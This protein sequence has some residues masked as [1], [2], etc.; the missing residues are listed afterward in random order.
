VLAA[1]EVQADLGVE[2]RETN[3]V[4]HQVQLRECRGRGHPQ[5]TT[6]GTRSLA[7]VLLGCLH[8]GEDVEAVLVKARAGVGEAQPP[9]RSVEEP[10]AEL[11]LEQGDVLAHHRARQAAPAAGGGEA[12]LGDDVDQGRDGVEAIHAMAPRIVSACMTLRGEGD[13][14][15]HPHSSVTLGA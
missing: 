5:A 6:R 2:L 10:C 12:P 9:G 13:R 4:L 3:E 15:S 7:H 1:V 8:R 14:L 11:R